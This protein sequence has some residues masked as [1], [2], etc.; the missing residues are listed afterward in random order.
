MVQWCD[1]GDSQARSS[2][3]TLLLVFALFWKWDL[4]GLYSTLVLLLTGLWVL[5][6][7]LC[8][9]FI[10]WCSCMVDDWFRKANKL[11]IDVIR[12]LSC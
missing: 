5:L 8:M 4:V 12:V 2:P 10:A 6:V 1:D 9:P 7:G 11:A 3:Y